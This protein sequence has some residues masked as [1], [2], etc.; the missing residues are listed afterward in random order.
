MSKIFLSL[1]FF[2]I[3]N[4]SFREQFGLFEQ[5][6]SLFY[7]FILRGSKF[8]IVFCSFNKDLLKGKVFEVRFNL[9]AQG[10]DKP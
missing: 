2:Q 7:P 9:L 5:S 10:Q 3:L 6:I 8:V 4:E 1:A